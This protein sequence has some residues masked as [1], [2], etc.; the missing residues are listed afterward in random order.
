VLEPF[1]KRELEE[2]DV[3]IEDA[4]DAVVTLLAEGLGRA[5]DRFNRGGP[6]PR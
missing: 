6:A 4:A 5:Q 3:L 1:A 2:V